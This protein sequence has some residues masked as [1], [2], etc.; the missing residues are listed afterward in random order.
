MPKYGDLTKTKIFKVHSLSHPEYFY[1][2]YTTQPLYNRI[3][4]LRSKH[5]AEL[6]NIFKFNDAIISLMENY[7]CDKIHDVVMKVNEYIQ[8]EPNCL[9]V[10]VIKHFVSKTKPT[11]RK[12]N[13]KYKTKK[14][15]DDILTGNP[16]INHNHSEHKF[17]DTTTRN[18]NHIETNH[19]ETNLNDDEQMIN[20]NHSENNIITNDNC[21]WTDTFDKLNYVDKQLMMKHYDISET[22]YDKFRKEKVIQ[23]VQK[24]RHI[25]LIASLEGIFAL[26]PEYN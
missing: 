14:L 23:E 24:R 12:A 11:Q 26:Q 18:H 1:F 19:N 21:V 25:I 20:H 4:T 9:N 16:N 15:N 22:E 2:D 13:I 10:K 3:A 6:D 7:P 5:D 17:N 8:L